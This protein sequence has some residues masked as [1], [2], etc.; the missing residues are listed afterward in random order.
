MGSIPKN[1]EIPLADVSFKKANY[2]SKTLDR[3]EIFLKNLGIYSVATSIGDGESYVKNTDLDF[4]ILKGF[5]VDDKGVQLKRDGK[6][7]YIDIKFKDNSVK[8]G[9][10]FDLSTF[11]IIQEIANE[12]Q[13]NG[14]LYIVDVPAFFTKVEKTLEDNTKR[15]YDNYYINPKTFEDSRFKKIGLK[16]KIN[17]TESKA[18]GPSN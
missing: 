2:G 4:V 18:Q 10:P 13:N 9:Q 11:P 8:G 12:V 7:V 3:K 1:V 6:P 5:L 17:P 16:E 14:K 15:L